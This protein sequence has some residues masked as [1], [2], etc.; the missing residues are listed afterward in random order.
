M[1]ANGLLRF[2]RQKAYIANTI[3]PLI[4]EDFAE[5]AD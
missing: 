1:G 4:M 5:H 2:F 3:S